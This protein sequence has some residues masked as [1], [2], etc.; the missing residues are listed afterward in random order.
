MKRTTC[1][2]LAALLTLANLLARSQGIPAKSGEGSAQEDEIGQIVFAGQ[3][4]PYR[5]RRLPVAS[6]PELPAAIAD[7]LTRRGC[8]I[9][10]TWQAHGPENVIHASLERP[11]SSDWAT[12]CAAQGTVSLL[13]FFASAPRQPLLLVTARETDRLQPHNGALTLGFNWGIDP[14]SPARIRQ[15]QAGLEHHPPLLDHDALADSLIDRR[16]LYHFFTRGNWVLLEM[17]AN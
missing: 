15:A 14:A 8:M 13:V 17:P 10:Q 16:T 9:P 12:L 2:L 7:E 5:I 1:I 11:G 4:L 6:F 3:A